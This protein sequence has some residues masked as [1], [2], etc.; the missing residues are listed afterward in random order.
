[1]AR[2]FQSHSNRYPILIGILRQ[3]SFVK[4]KA[5]WARAYHYS[6]NLASS[7]GPSHRHSGLLGDGTISEG[8]GLARWLRT[9]H[10]KEKRRCG[11]NV[12]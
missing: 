11:R 12:G 7:I 8:Y 2:R 10:S 6:G 4:A 3:V 9:K 5:R 1:M